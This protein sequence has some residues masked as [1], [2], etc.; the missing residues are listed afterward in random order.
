ME[1]WITQRVIRMLDMQDLDTL[2]LTEVF[3]EVRSSSNADLINI[4][5]HD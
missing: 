3:I 1:E 5:K 2:F 4:A